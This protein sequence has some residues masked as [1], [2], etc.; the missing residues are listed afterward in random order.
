LAELR[1]AFRRRGPGPALIWAIAILGCGQ[2]AATEPAPSSAPA[3][4]A[5]PTQRL[6]PIPA[7]RYGISPPFDLA[8]SIDVPAGWQTL[9]LL[10]GFTDLGWFEGSAADG[11]PERVIAFGHPTT[12]RGPN[13]DVPAAGLSAQAAVDLYR[14]RRDLVSGEAVP[15]EIDGRAGLRLDLHAPR[16]DTR[17]FSSGSSGLGVGPDVAI[18]YGIVPLDDGELLVVHVQAAPGDLEATWSAAA[19]ILDGIRLSPR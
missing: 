2:P 3:P 18:R 19:A 12:L 15:F 1:S 8:F 16:F 14:A 17:L 5:W 9:H 13:G 7:G 4:L 10:G 6:A 11:I